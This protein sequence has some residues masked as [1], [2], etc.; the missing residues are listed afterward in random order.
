M[1]ARSR[2]QDQERPGSKLVLEMLLRLIL[3]IANKQTLATG[4]RAQICPADHDLQSG[5][6]FQAIRTSRLRAMNTSR[7]SFFYSLPTK[8]VSVELFPQHSDR[9]PHPSRDTSRLQTCLEHALTAPH[10]FAEL[11]ATSGLQIIPFLKRV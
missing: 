6:S 5:D 10:V 9:V 11:T 4:L 1:L 8:N 7:P 2:Q 3:T